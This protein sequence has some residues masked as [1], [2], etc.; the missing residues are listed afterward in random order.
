MLDVVLNVLDLFKLSDFVRPFMGFVILTG[1]SGAMLNLDV[2]LLLGAAA[3]GAGRAGKS[4]FAVTGVLTL[5]AV[6]GLSCSVVVVAVAGLVPAVPGRDEDMVPIMIGG[7]AV[8]PVAAVDGLVLEDVP[9]LLLDEVPGLGGSF[10]GTGGGTSSESASFLLISAPKLPRLEVPSVEPVASIMPC[11]AEQKL[12]CSAV[13]VRPSSRVVVDSGPSRRHQPRATEPA[14][15]AGA[16]A[17][18]GRVGCR[19]EMRLQVADL[20]CFL[21]VPCPAASYSESPKTNENQEGEDGGRIRKETGW[22][23][24]GL[25]M[26]WDTGRS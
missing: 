9:G 22:R 1:F 8:F 13:K 6:P 15:S 12:K 25:G 7:P 20:D 17:R 4:P 18:A 26:S 14:A 16:P 21:G 11:R 5:T 2:R 24:P 19:I 3:V 10:G 23:S